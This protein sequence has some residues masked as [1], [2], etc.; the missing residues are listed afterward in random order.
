[1]LFAAEPD[2]VQFEGADA[3]FLG[4]MALRLAGVRNS[5]RNGATAPGRTTPVG[6]MVSACFALHKGRWG[7][8][9]P[10]DGSFRFNYEDHDFG[11]R[12]RA[13]GFHIVAVPGASCLHG[14]GTPGLSLRDSRAYPRARVGHLVKGR[15]V[16]LLK[17]FQLRTLIWLAP[18]LLVY[19]ACQLV[20]VIRRRWLREWIGASGEIVLELRSIL[21]K[22][23]AVQR[24][25]QLPD[26]AL[27]TGGPLPLRAD[28]PSGR[29][30]RLGL[31]LLERFSTA[32]W[33]LV[34]RAL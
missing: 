12:C 13:R 22:R 16:I 18:A 5:A 33:R 19:E 7:P 21:E 29:W 31:G 23:R 11:V 3:H 10:F 1:V 32:Y 28:F 34:R 27:L 6:S 26:R 8:E 20:L 30:E 17:C 2:V 14:E 4:L 9:P 24:V 15:W 25:R